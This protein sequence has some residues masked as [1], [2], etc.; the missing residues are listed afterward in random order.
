MSAR[1]PKRLSPGEE[2]F[3]LHCRAEGLSPER[4]YLFHPRRKWR[5]DFAFVREKLSVEIEGGIWSHGAHTRGQ[6]FEGDCV[7]YAH[8]AILGWRVIRCSTGQVT[9][10]QAI[11]WVLQALK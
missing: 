4:E 9:S 6:H 2:A 10:G 7:K 11:E 8:A 5:F 3:A 1:V